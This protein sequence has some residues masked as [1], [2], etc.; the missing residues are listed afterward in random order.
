MHILQ[1]F[2]LELFSRFQFP[3]EVIGYD[4]FV[5]DQ[6]LIKYRSSGI[7]LSVDSGMLVKIKLSRPWLFETL[8]A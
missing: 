7:S 6:K 4:S 2:V 5:P 3:K 8:L 1:F